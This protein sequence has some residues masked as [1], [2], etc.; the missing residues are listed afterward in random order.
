MRLDESGSV[1]TPSDWMSS[2]R[3]KKWLSPD[4]SEGIVACLAMAG[5]L[6]YTEARALVVRAGLAVR[7]GSSK[8]FCINRTEMCSLFAM[9]GMTYAPRTWR[10]WSAFHGLGVLKVRPREIQNPRFF[11][12]AV[13]FTHPTYGVVIFDPYNPYPLFQNEP[14]DIIYTPFDSLIPVRSWI[15][16]GW[17]EP[18]KN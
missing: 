5:G 14:L 6:D 8:P 10:G 3:I 1:H 16:V 9:A 13:A 12:Y 7:R 17:P 4:H 11:Y 2:C 18:S 15:Q